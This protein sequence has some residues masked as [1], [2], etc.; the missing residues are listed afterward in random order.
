MEIEFFGANCFRIKTKKTVVVVDDDLSSLGG[1]SILN[2]KT[3]SLYTNHTIIDEK[4]ASN[5]KLII[6]GPGEFEVGNLT[7]TGMQA[8][9]HTD[10]EDEYNATVYQLMA[11]GRTI[12]VLGHIHPDISSE[13]TE[14][15][16]GTD[17]LVV[18]VGGNGFTLDPIGAAKVIKKAEPEVIIP[19]HYEVKGLKYEVPAQSLAEFEKLPTVTLTEPQDSFKFGDSSTD[20]GV[21]QTRVLVLRVQTK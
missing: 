1:K 3:P 18:P 12:T 14:F 13:L 4:T 20:E 6:D 19:S 10:T 17:V 5:S 21:V 16:A 15:I 11:D 7:I 2:D 8:R 9:A